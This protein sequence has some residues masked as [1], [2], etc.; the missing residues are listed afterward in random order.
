MAKMSLY[1]PPEYKCNVTVGKDNSAKFEL[2]GQWKK[3]TNAVK[4]G[5]AAVLVLL[6]NCLYLWFFIWPSNSVSNLCNIGQA[7]SSISYELI[8]TYMNQVHVIVVATNVHVL[9][10]HKTLLVSLSSRSL[11]QVR[12][13]VMWV[14]D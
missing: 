6:L 5:A 8:W 9:Y 13:W 11:C 14:K 12:V 4:L 2:Y 10:V 1:R 3:I 7:Q